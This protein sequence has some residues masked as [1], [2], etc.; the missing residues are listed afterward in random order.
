MATRQQLEGN[1]KD[2]LIAMILRLQSAN[3]SLGAEL[4][5]ANTAL[6]DV[7]KNR[8]EIYKTLITERSRN[9]KTIHDFQ[10]KLAQYKADLASFVDDLVELDFRRASMNPKISP[11]YFMDYHLKN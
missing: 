6:H 10:S 3:Q 2:M 11:D 7:T 9:R 8:D 1:T 5:D 4:I